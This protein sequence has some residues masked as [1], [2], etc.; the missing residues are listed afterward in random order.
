MRDA[1]RRQLLLVAGF[2][3]ADVEEMDLSMDDETFQ[4]MVRKRLLGAMMNNGASQKVVKVDE[5]EG[6][7][8]RGWDFVATLP[9][10]KIIVRLPH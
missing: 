4:E 7:L 3:P 5:V 8:S 10:E 6:Y 2:S 1:F 9:D